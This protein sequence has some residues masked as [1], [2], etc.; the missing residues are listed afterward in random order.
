ML[1]LRAQSVCPVAELAMGLIAILA[2][3]VYHQLQNVFGC[4]IGPFSLEEP[5]FLALVN[6]WRKSLCFVATLL[7][8]HTGNSD[9]QFFKKEGHWDVFLILQ[10]Y[11]WLSKYGDMSLCSLALILW[12][13]ATL[14]YLK[15]YSTSKRF[16][17]SS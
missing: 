15:A 11:Y 5:R 12:R 17:E 13:T 8:F 4:G 2:D 10:S 9:L 1:V 16:V 3:F 14:L 7:A 6:F